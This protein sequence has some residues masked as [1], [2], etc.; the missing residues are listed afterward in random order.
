[1]V[2]SE[3]RALRPLKIAPTNIILIIVLQD[4]YLQQ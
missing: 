2:E 1:M 4:S 3:K